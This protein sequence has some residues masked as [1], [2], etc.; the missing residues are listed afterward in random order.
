MKNL[1]MAT[2]LIEA[3]AGAALVCCP[4]MVVS[5]LLGTPLDAPAAMTLGR[6]AGSAL[7][8]L[9]VA[10]WLATY[11][12]QSCA[13]R[14]VVSAMVVYNVGGVLV[15]GITGF[16][17]KTVGIALWPAVALHAGMGVWCIQGLS[18][19]ASGDIAA[20]EAIGRRTVRSI[21]IS[22]TLER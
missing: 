8:A 20:H 22:R 19:T 18:S 4:S 5:L 6:V 15:L 1:L 14:G 3:G 10:C 17:A 21:G 12:S 7:L 11:D 9:G 16:Q 13:A 2:A